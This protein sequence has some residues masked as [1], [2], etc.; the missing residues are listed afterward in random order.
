MRGVKGFKLSAKIR[1]CSHLAALNAEAGELPKIG[2]CIE[3]DLLIEL[4]KM[5]DGS[6]CSDY[7]DD[8]GRLDVR[9][10]D[11]AVVGVGRAPMVMVQAAEIVLVSSRDGEP[12][13]LL[14]LGDNAIDL[15]AEATDRVMTLEEMKAIRAGDH[16]LTSC[17]TN[18]A[19]EGD[20]DGDG[21]E[22]FN[23]H[24][25]TLGCLPE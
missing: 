11:G 1:N 3:D 21:L 24:V 7:L 23:F 4:A 13:T 17:G 16:N 6:F 18:A 10:L 15:E 14:C 22:L 12:G 20:S 5:P 19:H 9:K 2:I 8:Q 25:H